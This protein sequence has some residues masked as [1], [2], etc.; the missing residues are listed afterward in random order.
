VK[1]K[2]DRQFVISRTKVASRVAHGPGSYSCGS[3]ILQLAGAGQF[4]EA[5]A[6][7]EAHNR[8]L[9]ARLHNKRRLR[10]HTGHVSEFVIMMWKQY[11]QEYQNASI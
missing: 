6:L 3:L 2:K 10:P 4:K 8:E 7:A 11:A 9:P 5:V 1:L